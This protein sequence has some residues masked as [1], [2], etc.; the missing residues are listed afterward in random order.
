VRPGFAEWPAPADND[1]AMQNLTNSHQ[2]VWAVNGGDP[3]TGTLEVAGEDIRLAG[4]AQDGT[5]AACRIAATEL[6][7]VSESGAETDRVNGLRTVVLDER[8]GRRI[9]IAPQAGGEHLSEIAVLLQDAADLAGRLTRLVV[10]VPID[11]AQA[12]RV[13]ELVRRGPPYDL[14]QIPEVEHHEVYVRDRDVMFLF[15][16]ADPGLA[17]E[18]VMRDARVWSALERWDDYVT[19]PPSVVDP[20]YTWSRRRPAADEVTRS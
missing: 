18:R 11:P 19:G 5:G 7:H 6:F 4:H 1:S 9:L 16:G 13:R 12:E 14:N 3:I 8:G 10:R 15:E 20:D 17:V 2:V